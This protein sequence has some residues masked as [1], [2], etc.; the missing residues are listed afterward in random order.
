MIRT[1]SRTRSVENVSAEESANQ[2]FVEVE[3]A[4]NFHGSRSVQATPP[5]GEVRLEF[6]GRIYA[7]RFVME[8]TEGNQGREGRSQ[9]RWWC[10]IEVPELLKLAR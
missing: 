9:A 2:M 1:L 10:R 7:G 6:E 8:S 3:V 5:A 4:V